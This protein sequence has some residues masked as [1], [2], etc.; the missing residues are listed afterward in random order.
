MNPQKKTLKKSTKN[1]QKINKKIDKKRG[2]T[3]E[4][5]LTEK[6]KQTNKKRKIDPKRANS[7][8]IDVCFRPQERKTWSF[9]GNLSQ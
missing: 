3:D 5:H 1:L 9:Y 7:T 4:V 2:K 6:N 8:L